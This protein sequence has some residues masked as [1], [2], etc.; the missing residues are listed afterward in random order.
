MCP[1]HLCLFPSYPFPPLLKSPK[2]ASLLL[3]LVL[4]LH[5]PV[6]CGIVLGGH[7]LN[8][9]QKV[10]SLHLWLHKVY[11]KRLSLH[12]FYLKVLV[13]VVSCQEW[14][15]SSLELL[16]HCSVHEALRLHP[17]VCVCSALIS[18]KH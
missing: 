1:K 14:L 6:P 13:L 15:L 10:L 12:Y 5:M 11:I 7:F 2:F 8:Q 18:A 3:P 17:C 4:T 16:L 9:L